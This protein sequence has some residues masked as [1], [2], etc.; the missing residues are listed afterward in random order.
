MHEV[1]VDLLNQEMQ[2]L[3]KE[4]I[5]LLDEIKCCFDEEYY[6]ADV[7]GSKDFVKHISNNMGFIDNF[8]NIFKKKRASESSV[9]EMLLKGALHSESFVFVMSSIARLFEM[10]TDSLNEKI[11]EINIQS[12]EIDKDIEVVPLAYEELKRDMSVALEEFFSRSNA[13]LNNVALKHFKL[14]E[15]MLGELK[16]EVDSL[17]SFNSLDSRDRLFELVGY[18]PCGINIIVYS[19]LNFDRVILRV[20]EVLEDIFNFFEMKLYDEIFLEVN[21]FN[22]QFVEL[23]ESFSNKITMSSYTSGFYLDDFEFILEKYKLMRKLVFEC[24]DKLS[25]DV[26]P[27]RG[28]IKI[29]YAKSE[30]FFSDLLGGKHKREIEN[31]RLYE[32]AS[33]FDEYFI[34]DIEAFKN[35][36]YY[37]VIEI[38]KAV[39]QIVRDKAN[40]Q[41]NGFKSNLLE[42][43]QP[44][45]DQLNS[46]SLEYLNDIEEV[47]NELDELSFLKRNVCY[48]VNDI[49]SLKDDI[50]NFQY[51][52][53]AAQ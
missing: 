23:F 37:I 33:V 26:I 42:V 25:T 24:L 51:K 19:K 34:V 46:E 2:R 50:D 49:E 11:K 13:V 10:K 4:Y 28:D 9:K 48:F 1:S 14:F 22:K 21:V 32:D 45:F 53:G 12:E 20:K 27:S 3:F 38:L 36:F 15:H 39:N 40:Q 7:L 47:F 18:D 16:E 41:V 6:A 5:N 29:N 44:N 52:S 30:G 43:I 35:K 31:K 8:Y 17:T